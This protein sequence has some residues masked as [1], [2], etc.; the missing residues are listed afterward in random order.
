M[1]T[2]IRLIVSGVILAL[3]LAL[4]FVVHMWKSEISKVSTLNVQIAQ[5]QQVLS[6]K[7]KEESYLRASIRLSEETLEKYVGR[8]QELREK[9][10]QRQIELK[11]AQDEANQEYQSCRNL[12][13]PN[14]VLGLLRSNYSDYKDEN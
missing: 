2:K 5:Q 7:Q 8:Y 13:L 6:E 12:S 3:I 1:L 11:R 4:V 10:T 9:L 14:P